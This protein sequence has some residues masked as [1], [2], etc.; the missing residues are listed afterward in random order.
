MAVTALGR[1]AEI[2]DNE[3]ASFLDLY[4]S[5]H[6]HLRAFATAPTC[7]L[8]KVDVERY[9]VVNRFQQVLELRVRS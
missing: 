9:E 4:L 7:A 5:K 3:R 2:E 6:N 8:V 1:A